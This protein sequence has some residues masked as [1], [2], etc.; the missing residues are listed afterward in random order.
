MSQLNLIRGDQHVEIQLNRP[1]KK[2]ALN[3]GLIEELTIAFQEYSV[4]TSCRVIVLS[5]TGDVFS[6][7]ADLDG[8]RKM[9]QNTYAENLD[10]SLKLATL[11]RT[12]YLCDKPII[13]KI[14]GHA[15]AGGCG[16]LTLCD[17][18]VT[19]P[20]S[21]FGYSETRIGFVPAMV[22]RFLVAKVGESKARKL[23]LSGIIID[24]F[25]AEK[26]GLITEVTDKLDERI[27]FWLEH[28][29]KK[30]SPEAVKTTKQV[31][32]DTVSLN[33]DDAVMHAAKINATSRQS[34]DCI[35][36]VSAFLNKEDISW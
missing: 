9:Q 35:K 1:D 3:A 14:N 27:Q 7:G 13:G 25:E 23:L 30:V 10:D 34:S 20:V 19:L 21:K 33:W 28:F 31:L 16:L 24:A 32:R 4:D 12:M 17:I 36:G 11:F 22:A 6:A 15:I 18:S 29:T 8:L 5:G 26:I 2:N